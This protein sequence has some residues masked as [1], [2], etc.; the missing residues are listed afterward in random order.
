MQLWFSWDDIEK[1]EYGQLKMKTIGILPC[2]FHADEH[3]RGVC[4]HK[5]EGHTLK[6]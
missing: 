4:V 6:C 5:L 3:R 1:A 2:N